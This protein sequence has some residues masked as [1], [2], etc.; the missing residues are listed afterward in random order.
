MDKVSCSRK[1]HLLFVGIVPGTS[2]SRVRCFTTAPQRSTLHKV[3][4]AN[5]LN[6]NICIIDFVN[7]ILIIVVNTIYK[8]R[9]YIVNSLQVLV[10]NTDWM[11]YS[12]SRPF[13]ARV[14]WRVVVK[15]NCQ[16]ITYVALIKMIRSKI[17]VMQHTTW[18]GRLI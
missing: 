18:L 11:K 8:F 9:R 7:N 15:N 3:S 4:T 6:R 2:R 1:Q 14:A 16:S 12:S 5:V 13:G 10:L 17:V